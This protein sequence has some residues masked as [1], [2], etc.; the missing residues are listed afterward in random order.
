MIS[1]APRRSAMRGSTTR[2]SPLASR[3]RACAPS[4]AALISHRAREAPEIALDQV[5]AGRSALGEIGPFLLAD[6][7]QHAGLEQD[8]DRIGGDAGQV[9]HDLHGLLGLEDVDDRHALAGD[10]VPPI[11][12]AAGPGRRAADGRP[13]AR[14]AGWSI[15]PVENAAIQQFYRLRRVGAASGADQAVRDSVTVGR[16]QAPSRLRA[17]AS[18]TFLSSAA[19]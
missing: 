4:I 10:D 1:P 14:S 2:N 3:A 11:R 9:E 12:P 6:D 5:K 7:Q 13:A 8:A 18:E 17:Q 16:C 19:S 15:D